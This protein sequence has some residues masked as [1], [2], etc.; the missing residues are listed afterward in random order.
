MIYIK[1]TDG[2]TVGSFFVFQGCCVKLCGEEAVKITFVF[3]SYRK[4]NLIREET[5]WEHDSISNEYT[6]YTYRKDRLVKTENY[7]D[8]VLRYDT[9]Y[10]YDDTGLIQT[11]LSK[12]SD[13]TPERKYITSFDEYGNELEKVA[14]AYA[15]ELARF[16]MTDEDPDSKT[17][18]IYELKMP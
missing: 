2:L 16:G 12:Q 3:I 8:D 15:S 14:Y 9:Q 5:R 18:N 4:G 10:T 7:V 11:S 6:Q 1:K 17:I 13:G